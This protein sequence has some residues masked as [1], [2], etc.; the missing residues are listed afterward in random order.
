MDATESGNG[1][2]MRSHDATDKI[3]AVTNTLNRENVGGMLF[4]ISEQRLE[5]RVDFRCMR[6]SRQ[7]KHEETV[8]RNLIKSL[9]RVKQAT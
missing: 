8:A 5:S 9:Y 7:I 1:D 4:A 3:P 2:Y 6:I